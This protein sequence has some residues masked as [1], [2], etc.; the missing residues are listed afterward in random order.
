[1][2]LQTITDLPRVFHFKRENRDIN[3]PD[4]NT[5][6]KPE[7]VMMFYANDYPELI[8]AKMQGPM[9]EGEKILYKFDHQPGTKG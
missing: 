1:M 4:P 5:A 3:L 8:N 7:D 9:V 6:W 2:A